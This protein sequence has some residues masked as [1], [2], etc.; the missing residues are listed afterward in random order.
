MTLTPSIRSSV[1]NIESCEKR[2]VWIENI[3]ASMRA[4]RDSA[5]VQT[6]ACRTL[7][8]TV[9]AEP[10]TGVQSPI[11]DDLMIHAGCIECI[12]TALKLHVSNARVQNAAI[13]LLGALVGRKESDVLIA[14]YGCIELVL[15]AMKLHVSNPQ[16]QNAAIELLG[17]L[18][19]RKENDVLIARYGGIKL[20]LDAMHD[21][22][23]E[24]G[25]QE[26]GCKMLRNITGGVGAGAV[27]FDENRAEIHELISIENGIELILKAMRTF[28]ENTLVQQYGCD[29][30]N[31]LAREHEYIE[32]IVEEGGVSDVVHA[33]QKHS[34]Y[35]E[36]SRVVESCFAVLRKIALEGEF[37]MVIFENHGLRAIVTAMWRHTS[38]ELVQTRGCTIIC[39]VATDV[40]LDT[41]FIREG[42]RNVLVSALERYPNNT[43]IRY[44]VEEFGLKYD[45]VELDDRMQDESG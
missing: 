4:Y 5:K 41:N 37:N 29:V 18:V 25:I 24:A 16:V 10:S 35:K 1:T 3:L 27:D 17:A 19:G 40:D 14:R 31:N 38:N 26:V 32:D 45:T 22:D 28:S 20:V 15:D 44:C 33:L 6:S 11:C 34:P 7:L 36:F 9:S 42:C 30:L 21:L 12:S 2:A 23:D 43:M 8:F 39:A 13:E